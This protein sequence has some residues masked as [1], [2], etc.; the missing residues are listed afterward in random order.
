M[1][2][3]WLI[4]STFLFILFIFDLKKFELT[5]FWSF[6]QKISKLV[7]LNNKSQTKIDILIQSESNFI[8]RFW[9]ELNL[10][11]EF[12]FDRFESS[13]IQFVTPNCP[14]LTFEALEIN[15]RLW[16]ELMKKAE[17]DSKSIK[18]NFGVN[19]SRHKNA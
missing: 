19:I 8:I 1:F 7:D 12:R 9:I 3:K 18:I 14:E 16:L 10:P 17:F 4:L 15:P 6:N 5:Y 2:N 13:T 11:S